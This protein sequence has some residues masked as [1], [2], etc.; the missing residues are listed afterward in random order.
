MQHCVNP[1]HT[2]W[3]PLPPSFP[4]HPEACKSWTCTFLKGSLC[5]HLTIPPALTHNRHYYHT[6]PFPHGSPGSHPVNSDDIPD[7]TCLSGLAHAVQG[8]KLFC[9]ISGSISC[10]LAL[11]SSRQTKC[12]I[13]T[14]KG[15]VPGSWCPPATGRPLLPVACRFTASVTAGTQA[16]PCSGATGVNVMSWDDFSHPITLTVFF[17]VFPGSSVVKVLHFQGRQLGFIPWSGN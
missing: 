1:S 12:C 14:F 9:P 6:S 5:C 4:Q 7:E 2:P 15:A 17:W 10:V 11:C 16:E 13:V 8:Q 3:L